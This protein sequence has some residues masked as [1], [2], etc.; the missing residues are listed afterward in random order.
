MALFSLIE[1]GGTAGIVDIGTRGIDF[2]TT[3]P[4]LA[5]PGGLR[6]SS[7]PGGLLPFAA[8]RIVTSEIG[9]IGRIIMGLGDTLGSIFDAA[10]DVGSQLI[11]ANNLPPTGGVASGIPGPGIPGV[12]TAFP[13]LPP[14]LGGAARSPVVQGALGGLAGA[15]LPSLF[16][17]GG[18]PVAGGIMLADS[19]GAFHETAAGNVVPRRQWIAVNPS[20]G[21]L[22]AFK[23][24]KIKIVN[25]TTRR[26]CRP[27]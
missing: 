15:A 14:I 6:V 8:P 11:L 12:L 18:Q 21:R 26:R 25:R 27:R 10:I 17:G 1:G 5:R 20:T 13:A 7:G 22:T 2:P 3:G 23:A 24:A 9:Q 16:G 4:A 19:P